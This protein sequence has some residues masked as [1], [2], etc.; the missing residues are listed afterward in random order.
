MR[1]QYVEPNP[2]LL[3]MRNGYNGVGSDLHWL[4]SS[5][6]VALISWPK[7]ENK[8]WAKNTKTR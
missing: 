6:V 2:L 4:L 8:V 3:S 5:V 1:V 7:G